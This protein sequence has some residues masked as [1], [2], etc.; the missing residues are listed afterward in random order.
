MS[1]KRSIQERAIS[2]VS[3]MAD[4]MK[5]H[6]PPVIQIL[7]PKMRDSSMFARAVKVSASVIATASLLQGAQAADFEN[8]SKRGK[9]FDSARYVLQIDS[10]AAQTLSIL[11]KYPEAAEILKGV[12]APNS[13]IGPLASC[14]KTV[15]E[16]TGVMPDRQSQIE[17]A[18]AI[19]FISADGIEITREWAARTD[20]DI[21]IAQAAYCL[22]Q[23]E[24]EKIIEKWD[25][26]AQPFGGTIGEILIQY[27]V[28]Q[29]FEG[30]DAQQKVLL[31]APNR[32][33]HSIEMS[34]APKSVSRPSSRMM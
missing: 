12:A 24:F 25:A 11:K 31:D 16:A 8:P 18:L 20:R 3:K 14:V 10:R 1:A 17:T 29:I 15:F 4:S 5:S 34:A 33:S 22:D 26:E 27:K 21:R 2:F 32:I 9:G 6:S 19:A 23:S 30:L 7:S 13:E 28:K